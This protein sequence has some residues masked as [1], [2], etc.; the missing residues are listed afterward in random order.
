MKT[1]INVALMSLFVSVAN[2]QTI[3]S[4]YSSDTGLM[5]KRVCSKIQQR[6]HYDRFDNS[7]IVIPSNEFSCRDEIQ[8][9]SK[10]IVAP[11]V[12]H[13]SIPTP[14]IQNNVAKVDSSRNEYIRDC[15]SY[16]LNR[17]WCE[18][19]WDGVDEETEES[20]NKK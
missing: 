10:P 19:N 1:Y 9:Y 3:V 18:K 11:V 4:S 13:Q 5:T 17:K 14:S 6:I 2:A 15:V 12:V 8:V 16:G 20:G 7:I